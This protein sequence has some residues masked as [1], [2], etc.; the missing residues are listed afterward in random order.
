MEGFVLLALGLLLVLS[1][2]VA[3]NSLQ[4]SLFN[5]SQFFLFFLFSP[6]QEQ[7]RDLIQDVTEM[8]EHDFPVRVITAFPSS[9]V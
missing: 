1:L 9:L 8:L 2:L 6:M 5:R 4:Y 7:V 3:T